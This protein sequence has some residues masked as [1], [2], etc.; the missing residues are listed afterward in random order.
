MRTNEIVGE[1]LRSYRSRNKLTLE[2]IAEQSQE[3]GTNWSAATIRSLEKGGSKADSVPV[4]TLL[5]FTLNALERRQ[6]RDGNI[7]IKDII[8]SQAV[9]DLTDS[10][11]VSTALVTSAWKKPVNPRGQSETMLSG[12]E[13]VKR[14]AM[15][16]LNS[17][18][19]WAVKE[20]GVPTMAEKRLAKRINEEP[21]EVLLA[22]REL[23]G[24]SLDDEATK[25][26]GIDANSQKRGR[27]TRSI[28]S[29]VEQY[30]KKQGDKGHE[31]LTEFIQMLDERKNELMEDVFDDFI[32]S[33][34]LK[35]S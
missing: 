28:S 27:A 5:V 4:L 14:K 20:Y 30:L 7:V 11:T 2:D 18:R 1:Y 26:A 34:E 24:H 10:E 35:V 23:Y 22:C 32:E 19:A 16:M 21:V 33:H 29:E 12:L 6:G 25:R 3:F 13:I 31:A 15:D 9:V 8:E 17:N